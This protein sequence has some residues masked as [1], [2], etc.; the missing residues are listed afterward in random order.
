MACRR[1]QSSNMVSPPYRGIGVSYFYYCVAP[2]GQGSRV[3]PAGGLS[4]VHQRTERVGVCL[5]VSEP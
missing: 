5:V 1:H 2:E 4:L 3:L